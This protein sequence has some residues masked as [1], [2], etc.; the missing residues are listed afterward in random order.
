[1]TE[2]ELFTPILED[3]KLFDT[4]IIHRH[5]NPDGDAIGSQ[6][7]LKHLIKENFPEKTVYLVGDAAGRYEFMCDQEFDEI[8]DEVYENALAIV[9]DTSAAHLIS[10][11]RWTKAKKNARFDHHLF[12]EKLADDEAILTTY[13]SCCGVIGA[14]AKECNLMLSE[15][16]ATALYTGMVTDSG[17]FLYDS[18]N[19][20]TFE[21]AAFLM[22]QPIKTQKIF[23]KLYE[24]SLEIVQR[25][26][27]FVQKIKLTEH[28][29]AYI[30]TCKEE[31]EA[32]N[33]DA[34]SIS[35]GMVG[36]M[37]DIKGIDIWVNFTEDGNDI[38]AELRSSKYNI[39][40]V[41][42]KYGGG[43]HQKAS[44]ATLHSQKEVM[45]MLKDLDAMMLTEP[46]AV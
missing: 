5:K 17:R 21:I 24:T 19:G 27:R 30:Y 34:F 32:E 20:R 37:A 28:N 43:G 36:C 25:R 33:V 39:N 23:S 8:S 15:E 41:A 11:D 42:V 12:V 18:T 13:E 6:F 44:G 7:G 16:A 35:R 45:E 29:V 26:A 22:T 1:M 2:L 14:F 46:D 4:I 9:C 38:C 3:I 10:D 31:V 40:P